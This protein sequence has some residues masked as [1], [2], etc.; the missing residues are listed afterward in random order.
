M[1]RY[2]KQKDGRYRT[3]IV[4]G[5][6]ARG[7]A[8][9]R[10]VSGR[11]L[12]EL[13]DNINELKGLAP[14]E[15]ADTL[16]GEYAERWYK[17]YKEPHLRAS[18]A[19]MYRYILDV[20]ILPA[21]G[22]R[23]LRT[24]APAE[25]QAY[26][27]G[28]AGRSTSLIDKNILTL[29]QLFT[30][31]EID[32]VVPRNPM[33]GIIVPKGA[34]GRKRALTGAETSALLYAGETH[35]DGLLLLLLYYTG[36]RRG[37]V[38]GLKRKDI[39]FT[40]GLIRVRRQ[41]VYVNGAAHEQE[42][43]KTKAGNRDIPLLSP[44]RAALWPRRGLPHVFVLTSPRTGGYLPQATFKRTWARMMAAAGTP[45]IT[46]HYLRHNFATVLYD[47]GVDVLEAKR[48]LGHEDYKTTADT[49][50]HL[51]EKHRATTAEK[52]EI[53]VA[54]KKNVAKMLPE[55]ASAGI[56]KGKEKP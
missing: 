6:D 8:I 51:G 39:D 24:I 47:A 52:L 38:L 4:V 35:A 7:K 17:A 12:K 16:L 46:P 40:A 33:R 26:I 22:N 29:R 37:E 49:Y 3:R 31:A 14:S 44:L 42:M 41:V 18:T 21:F 30:R 56:N 15:R 27:N 32:G 50:T 23:Q 19:S 13:D 34:A 2:K 53:E 25:I 36:M 20:H 9:M 11:T 10:Y 43:T 48:I 1:A 55:A 5:H 45:D 54:E 28:F